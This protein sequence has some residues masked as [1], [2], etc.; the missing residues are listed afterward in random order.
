MTASYA[1]PAARAIPAPT[2]PE[3]HSVQFYDGTEFLLDTVAVHVGDGL[4]AGG[5]AV[6]IAVEAHRQAIERRLRERGIDVTAALASDRYLSLDAAHTLSLCMRGDE[7][8]PQAFAEVVGGIIDRAAAAGGTVRAFGEMVALLCARGQGLAAVQLED[9]WNEL[10]ATRPLSLLCGYPLGGFGDA[11]SAGTFGEIVARHARV[12]PT[13][14]YLAVDEP[15]DRLREVALLQQQAASAIRA[16]TSAE[17]FFSRASHELRTP[18]NAILGFADLL[19]ARATSLTRRE[20][21]YLARL[22]TAGEDLRRLLEEVLELADLDAGRVRLAPR[23]TPVANLL[24]PVTTAAA[25]L[26]ARSGLPFESSIGDAAMLTRVDLRR[27]SAALIELVRHSVRLPEQGGT[28]RVSARGREDRVEIEVFRARTAVAAAELDGFFD[29]FPK[30][31]GSDAAR[32]EPTRLGLAFARKVVELHGGWITA[33]NV[34]GT[35]LTLR[36]GL[37]VVEVPLR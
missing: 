25:E 26:C 15:A 2:L 37:P 1:P 10:S 35:G 17:A 4:T 28:V 3:Q 36:V 34:A 24:D 33:E 5:A 12:Y 16:T 19:E 20:A 7:L 22:R 21:G 23:T 14:R 9:L 32:S 30:Q 13:E 27:M 18:L 6:V 8:D 31:Y 29:A 11:G